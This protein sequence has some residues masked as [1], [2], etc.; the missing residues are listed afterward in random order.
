MK[1]RQGRFYRFRNTSTIYL[2]L[3][4]SAD[5]VAECAIIQH[6]T[7]ASEQTLQHKLSSYADWLTC[8]VSPTFMDLDADGECHHWD[9]A[10]ATETAAEAKGEYR[11]PAEREQENAPSWL[12]Q[13]AQEY[14]G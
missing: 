13:I 1:I 9:P 2:V 8:E 10:Q 11:V 4:I 7:T 12:E 6:G 14:D 5:D 3:S